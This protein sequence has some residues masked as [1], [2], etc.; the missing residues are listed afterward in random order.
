MKTIWNKFYFFNNYRSKKSYFYLIK[1]S[2]PLDPIKVRFYL[3][4]DDLTTQ[5]TY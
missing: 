3:N 1:L 4:K 5:S 2:T